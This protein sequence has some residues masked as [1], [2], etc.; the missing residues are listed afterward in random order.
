MKLDMHCHTREGSLDGKIPIYEYIR[1]LQSKGFQGMLVTDHDS[2]NG[3]REYRDRIKDRINDFVVLKGI[4]YDTIDA[5]HILVILPETV[6]LV[7]MECRGLPV[8]MLQDIVHKYGGVLGPAHPCG[9]RHLSITRTRSFKKNPDIMKNFD[10]LEGFNSCE[11]TESNMEARRL[12]RRYNLPM[13]GGSDSHHPGCVGTAYTE[14]A[15]DIRSESELISYIKEKKETSNGGEFYKRT[16]KGKLGILGHILVE[17]FWFYNRLA[18]MC[19]RRKRKVALSL[20][21]Q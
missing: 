2:Y 18:S 5:G 14:L 6:K 20:L 8:R 10:F 4:E 3:F 9:G 17:S 7:L 19:R 15:E 1:I 12:A 11:T 16:V 13:L 21:G